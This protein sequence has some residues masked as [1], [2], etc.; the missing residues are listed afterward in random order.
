MTTETPAKP[1]M[2]RW[3]RVVLV[4]SLAVNFVVIGLVGGAALHFGRSGPPPHISDRGG[5]L[6]FK[7]LERED[8]REIGKSIRK[9]YREYAKTVGKEKAQYKTIA[10]AIE[11]DPMDV[12][13]LRQASAA[14]DDRMT[15]RRVIARD[16][17]LE[18]VSSMT[19]DE[20][21]AYAARLREI[22]DNPKKSHKHGSKKDR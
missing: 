10:D 2:K 4:L 11:A 6:I 8:R 16:A 1:G 18:K 12:D 19:V 13:A 20:R 9:S 22:L 15:Q 17:W 14:I 3:L 7:A 5:V 21:K